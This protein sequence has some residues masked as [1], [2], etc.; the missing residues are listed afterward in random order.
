MNQDIPLKWKELE[1]AV[2]FKNAFLTLH[3]DRCLHPSL[4]EHN[5]YVFDFR[6]WV[7]IVPITTDGQVVLVKQYRRGTD[8]I[9]LEIPAG[10]LDPGET[11]PAA[12][13]LRELREETGY[14]PAE[15]RLLAKAAVNPAIQN[16]FCYLYLA[17]GCELRHAISPDAT[18]ELVVE[19]VPLAKIREKIYSG[20]IVHSLGML[21]L[22]LALDNL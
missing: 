14:V 13:A 17:T 12:G 9:T 4:G 2:V 6:D 3:R 5:F 11:D 10:S 1:T 8:S 16:N 18:E 21:G 7:N 20:A 15:M 19:L 22:M